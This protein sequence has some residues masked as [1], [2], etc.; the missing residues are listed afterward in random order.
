MWPFSSCANSDACEATPPGTITA[1]SILALVPFIAIFISVSL[2]VVRHI[3]PKLN[4]SQDARD[5]EEHVLPAHAPAALRQAH[6]EH[7]AKSWKR[8]GAAWTFGITI[9]LA[10]TLA[11]LILDEIL[12][13][14]DP[15]ARDLA[16]WITVPTLLFMLVILVPW[17]EAV[18]RAWP[19][20][21][22]TLL[23][24]AWLFAFWS[25][26]R[27]VPIGATRSIPEDGSLSESLTRGCLERIGVVGISLMAL[28]AGFAS[29]SS[30]WHTFS[31]AAG[32][33][34]RPVTEADVNRKQAGLEAANEMLLTKRH[35]LQVLERKVADG[36]ATPSSK[37]GGFVGK[38]MGS[39]RGATGD[40]AEMRSLRL[41]ITGLETMEA[42]LASSLS[43]LKN[44]RAATVRAST[45]VGRVLLVP[46][47]VFSCYCLYRIAATTLTT[48]RR[49]YSPSASFAS[50]DPINRF[51]GLLAKHW[52]PKL[53]QL[54]WARTISFALSGVILLASANS[55]V[56]TFHLFAKWTPGLLRQAE[57]NLALVV[58]QIAATYVISSS[59]LL[60]SQL[61]VALGSAVGSV[62]RG[63]LSPGFVDGWFE[64]WFLAGSL[65]TAVGIWVGRK[66][67]GDEDWDEYGMEE[68]GAKRS[69]DFDCFSITYSGIISRATSYHGINH[70]R[71]HLDPKREGKCYDICRGLFDRM[72]PFAHIKTIL[73]KDDEFSSLLGQP[74]RRATRL[75]LSLLMAI[76]ICSLM[77]M[78]VIRNPSWKRMHPSLDSLMQHFL[79]GRQ[80]G[81]RGPW[82]RAIDS[83]LSLATDSDLEFHWQTTNNIKK[84][85][86]FQRGG[87]ICPTG[88]AR[89]LRVV[90]I[91][92]FCLEP[93][94]WPADNA[95]RTF[96]FLALGSHDQTLLDILTH[97]HGGSVAGNYQHWNMLYIDRKLLPYWK[98]AQF[99]IKCVGTEPKCL[100]NPPEELE[101]V[102]LKLQFHW[103]DVSAGNP[104]DHITPEPVEMEA[105]VN[106]PELRQTPSG[107]RPLVPT[108]VFT[109]EMEHEDA[110][111][112]KLMIDMQW[113]FL[114]IAAMSGTAGRQDL[115]TGNN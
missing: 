5:G 82:G 100:K 39:I 12:E 38:M 54:A 80:R 87:H 56:Q 9:G 49:A 77:Q 101:K 63:A 96:I 57:A 35:R 98:N 61:P 92:P 59:L 15:A 11:A 79:T 28:L 90:Q 4:R 107:A 115:L 36:Q 22:Q 62:L 25:V 43:L 30:P 29:V 86:C 18:S 95:L 102:S 72:D 74:R 55:V 46:S 67:G 109:I 60:R 83:L 48:V 26:G 64:G 16:L 34:K 10:A 50:S 24:A 84:Y 113:A 99:G 37:S 51:L 105:M 78:A 45:P 6:A 53:D 23:F 32:R 110:K 108:E 66:L 19:W 21:L 88:V 13:V 75:H 20:A 70:H 65:V 1:A 81:H 111:K 94:D 27:A 103:M 68:M 17:L 73:N 112:M 58:G 76:P 33:R 40:E 31:D 104:R 14:V 3:F 44:H 69:L 71:L 97:V 2:L 106:P 8:R 42:N 85:E 41:D 89:K 7:G 93:E 91:F 114:R 52:D 47:Y